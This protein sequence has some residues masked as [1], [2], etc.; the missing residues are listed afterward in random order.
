MRSWIKAQL[1]R[2]FVLKHGEG[3]PEQPDVFRCLKCRRLVTWALIRQGGC[4]CGVKG[5]KMETLV[6]RWWHVARLLLLPSTVTKPINQS[7][8]HSSG[9]LKDWSKI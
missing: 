5:A 9:R 8:G 6:L 2:W 4:V 3:H 7:N 1:R